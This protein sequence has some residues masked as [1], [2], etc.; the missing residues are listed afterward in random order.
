MIVICGKS[1]EMINK[2]LETGLSVEI[3]IPADQ[4]RVYQ[5]PDW[6][7]AGKEFREGWIAVQDL[8]G[9]YLA[10]GFKDIHAVVSPGDLTIKEIKYI[11]SIA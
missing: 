11:N 4:W 5:L 2:A 3:T 9:D 7:D 10:Q 8:K 6:A 1:A